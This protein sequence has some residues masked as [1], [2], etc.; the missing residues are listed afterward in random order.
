MARQ[1]KKGE[2]KK[3]VKE[4]TGSKEKRKKYLKASVGL[5]RPH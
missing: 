3:K 5:Y 4:W 2:G 1:K